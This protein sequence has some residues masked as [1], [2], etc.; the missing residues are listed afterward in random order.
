MKNKAKRAKKQKTAFSLMVEYQ[1]RLINYWRH[2][3]L[4][5]HGMGFY[6][7]HLEFF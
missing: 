3:G 4:V 2:I 5:H 1:V 6:R 7:I